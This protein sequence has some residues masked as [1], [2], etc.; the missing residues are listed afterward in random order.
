V[1]ELIV[2]PNV[3]YVIT[4]PGA[5]AAGPVYYFLDAVTTSGTVALGVTAPEEPVRFIY[6]PRVFR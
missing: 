4:D 3:P 5:P 1:G 6:L 2:A